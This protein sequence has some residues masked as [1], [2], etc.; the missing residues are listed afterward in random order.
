MVRT[1]MVHL[2]MIIS[3]DYGDMHGGD[4]V[5]IDDVKDV[6]NHQDIL[7]SD[8]IPYIKSK[9]DRG[10]LNDMVVMFMSHFQITGNLNYFLFK[11]AKSSCQSYF[12]YARFIGELESA[13]LEIYRRQIAPYEDKKI[14]E[15]EDV[16]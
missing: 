9:D 8:I 13:K 2:R 12:D 7:G 10:F 15:K 6:V 3:M 16:N 5:K 14:K 11:L 4:M 1:V